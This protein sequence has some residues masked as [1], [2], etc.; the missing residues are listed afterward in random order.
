MFLSNSLLQKTLW[1]PTSTYSVSPSP[2]Q[3]PPQFPSSPLPFLTE[4]GSSKQMIGW[5]TSTSHLRPPSSS[6]LDDLPHGYV[7]PH[8][9]SEQLDLKTSN[10]AHSNELGSGWANKWAEQSVSAKQ[11][12][13]GKQGGASKWVS[14]VTGRAIGRANGPVFTS[15]FLV[16]LDHS[17]LSFRAIYASLF[18]TFRQVFTFWPSFF[19]WRKKD[20]AQSKDSGEIADAWFQIIF[21]TSLPL[22]VL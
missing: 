2:P 5:L 4:I 13:W 14:G 18:H 11:V 9:G 19:Y 6:N 1:N 12:V 22:K 8:Y 16:V 17:G 10:H 21:V 3:Q 15:V 20:H 7:T